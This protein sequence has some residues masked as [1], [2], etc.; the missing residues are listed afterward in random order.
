MGDGIKFLNLYFPDNTHAVVSMEDKPIHK[1]THLPQQQ[2]LIFREHKFIYQPVC[3]V[4]CKTIVVM[5][6]LS[7]V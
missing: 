2:P 6:V 1:T 4:G 3:K 5:F 7:R